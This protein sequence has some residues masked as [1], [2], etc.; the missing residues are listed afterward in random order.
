MKY[1]VPFCL[2][3]SM[4]ANDFCPSCQHIVNISGSAYISMLVTRGTLRGRPLAPSST[5][6]VWYV[7]SFFPYSGIK[8]PCCISRPVIVFQ[9]RCIPLEI[10]LPMTVSCFR[11]FRRTTRTATSLHVGPTSPDP[12]MSIVLQS[13]RRAKTLAALRI[14]TACSSMSTPRPR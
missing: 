13:A 12:D 6:T 7:F 8:S 9:R 1:E 10:L 4:L 2:S 5:P 11:R 3:C 14:S